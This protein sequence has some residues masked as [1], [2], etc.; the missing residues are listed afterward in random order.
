MSKA[1]GVSIVD[2]FE[3]KKF[4][5]ESNTTQDFDENKRQSFSKS[6]TNFMSND[7]LILNSVSSPQT[8]HKTTTNEVSS[9]LNEPNYYQKVLMTHNGGS[10]SKYWQP[11]KQV[12]SICIYFMK[13]ATLFKKWKIAF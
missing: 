3:R 13:F 1:E 7:K 8:M 5:D 2:Q 9:P 6:G 4:E 12:I 10:M 11:Q